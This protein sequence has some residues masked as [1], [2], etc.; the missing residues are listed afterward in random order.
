VTRTQLSGRPNVTA[1]LVVHDGMRWLPEVLA[2]IAAQTRAPDRL[3]AVDTGSL[4]GS[5]A[6][7]GAVWGV[8]VVL[9]RDA[10]FGAAV[11]AGLADSG[12]APAGAEGYLWLL[13]D[14]AVPA[15][16][17][18]EE[19]LA[20]AARTSAA[21]VGCKER[22]DSDPRVVIGLGH[23]VDRAGRRAG[24]LVPAE[25]DQGQ[26]DAVVATAPV[27]AVSTAGLLARR[28]A[29]EALGGLDPA[30]PLLHDDIDLG[31]RA[32]RAGLSVA[33]APDALLR[34]ARA[35]ARGLRE[36]DVRPHV[37]PDTAPG[38]ASA[39]PAARRLDR[40][41]AGY[42]QAV[43]A[44]SP[45]LPWVLLR[46]AVGGLARALGALLARHP[47]RAGDEA[48]AALGLLLRPG[49]LR[50][51]RDWRRAQ[52]A[53]PTHS[54]RPLLAP[55]GRTAVHRVGAAVDRLS[56]RSIRAVAGAADDT[57]EVEASA[58]TA[59]AV[60]AHPGLLLVVVLTVI[61]L[62]A[63][64]GLIGG[65]T[66]VG[67]R[68]LPAP[69][70]ARALWDSW[71][72]GW[73]PGPGG[74]TGTPAAPWTPWLAALSTLTFGRP[75]LA[76]DVLVLGAVPLAGWSA[77]RAT[78]RL[79]VPRGLRVWAA[80]VWATLPVATGAVAAG[81][82]DACVAVIAV[83]VLL[84]AGRDILT[85]SP[86]R[87]IRRAWGTGLGLAVAAA[88]S[89]PL[90]TAGVV[91]VV[92][93][94]VILLLLR[95]AGTAARIR[96]VAVPLVPA[97]LLALPWLSSVAAQPR[98]LLVGLGG[99]G[100]LA[101]TPGAHP[102]GP[103]SLLLLRPGG[104]GLPA[105]V[106]V[107]PLLAV[108]VVLGVAAAGRA[109]S[110]GRRALGAWGVALVGLALAVAGSRVVVPVAGGGSAHG[111]PGPF[112][113]V[114]GA[115]V[116]AA[117]LFGA[118]GAAAVLAGSS[119]GW[120]Q[121]AAALLTACCALEPVLAGAAWL[122][123][124]ADAPV[125]RRD[126][127]VL[128]PD[129][130]GDIAAAH[131][132][133][134]RV[135]VLST[136]G[137]GAVHWDLRGPAGPVLGDEDRSPSAA[138][139]TLLSAVVADLGTPRGSDAG[140]VLASFDVRAVAV[141]GSAPSALT[142]S[143]DTQAG[144]VRRSTPYAVALWQLAPGIPLGSAQVL[145]PALASAA[146]HPAAVLAGSG[147]APSLAELAAAPPTEV[148]AGTRL[149]PGPA[150]RLLVLSDAAGSGWHARLDGSVLP[151]ARAWGWAQAFR[152]PPGGG[153]LVVDH[154]AGAR[155]WLVGLALGAALVVV[156]LAAPSPGS[157]DR[158]VDEAGRVA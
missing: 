126:V 128:P 115:G 156:V 94:V 125:A 23:T 4:D 134:A 36:I 71:T 51:G 45:L 152:L 15:P 146:T 11:A 65:G 95:G 133:D 85:G 28:S 30:L 22:S 142:E 57:D 120:R 21:L 151:S 107:A 116:L 70:S 42:V 141:P 75:S 138:A 117:V 31:W 158:R 33:V 52:A 144:L 132:P 69:G 41:H 89:P 38:S 29:W 150:G 17:A 67:G 103:L 83:P 60:G 43:N 135:L 9:G 91:L 10:G 102:P 37:G 109:G 139:R 46:W 114:A 157:D 93:C 77:W 47:H 8:P 86:E 20:V 25:V 72:A 97:P 123:R 54:V 66:L 124:G 40:R 119:F 50:T 19:L 59:R 148:V 63:E 113:A 32:A 90:W 6:H 127:V 98:V 34:H 105:A 122:V 79:P 49:Q 112:L 140:L 61:A 5:A 81:R 44:P 56:G 73:D 145:G 88:F 82:F 137:R 100:G 131:D 108:V 14:D 53:A 13:H 136:G 55:W 118:H 24:R 99:V 106:W 153:Q 149:P 78:R 18:L 147:R 39:G 130:L 26:H 96:A 155:S 3:V 104:P 35:A 101:G 16:R 92:G 12:A 62:I 121:L 76:V 129:L 58:R 80:A 27:L 74:G 110:A 64:R 68:L 48:R 154:D 2:G 143:L 1:V 7:L 87:R 84:A 111:W